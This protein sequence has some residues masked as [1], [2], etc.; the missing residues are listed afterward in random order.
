MEILLEIEYIYIYSFALGSIIAKHES[1]S[2]GSPRLYCQ[3]SLLALLEGPGMM[4]VGNW[5]FMGK[6]DK[7][8]YK[9]EERTE[10][11]QLKNRGKIY[12]EGHAR[13]SENQQR[14]ILFF[15]LAT[16]VRRSYRTVWSR[17]NCTT[18]YHAQSPNLISQYLVSWCCTRVPW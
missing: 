9:N 2:H 16:A 10:K 12:R 5:C 4:A 17:G 14:S 15:H 3:A 7:G 8:I 13:V 6:G 11:D 1:C 18:W